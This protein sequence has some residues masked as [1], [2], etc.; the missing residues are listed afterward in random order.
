MELIK[1]V[2]V[3]KFSLG[4]ENI[5]YGAN[6]LIGQTVYSELEEFKDNFEHCDLRDCWI[7]SSYFL[8]ASVDV[9]KSHLKEV[10]SK[11][12]EVYNYV[13][14]VVS[15]ADTLTN[16]NDEM[17]DYL[18]DS[19]RTGKFSD[20]LHNLDYSDLN[21][22]KECLLSSKTWMDKFLKFIEDLEK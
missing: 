17:N 10:Y 22:I 15:H 20:K 14:T 21:N 12:L 19:I 2:S 6:D 4:T 7:G 8:V 5:E 16:E 9:I 13:E 18:W 11:C 1:G 3:V